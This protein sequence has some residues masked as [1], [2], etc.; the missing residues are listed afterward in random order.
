[1]LALIHRQKESRQPRVPMT[2]CD[3]TFDLVVE[4]LEAVNYEGPLALSCDDSK[5]FASLRLYWDNKEEKHFLVG[6]VGGPILVPNP[7]D[8]KALMSD[9][10]V[11]KAVKVRLIWS[12]LITVK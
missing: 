9:P 4:Y 2:I 8:I 1:M 11:V 6:A 10:S 12:L 7:D 5:L 3:R